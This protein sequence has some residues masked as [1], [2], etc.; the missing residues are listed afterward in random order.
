MRTRTA[1]EIAAI[2]RAD[3]VYLAAL[4]T[5]AACSRLFVRRV[6]SSWQF[7]DERTGIVELLVSELASN[8]IQASGAAEARLVG[9]PAS[10]ERKLIGIRLL[11]FQASLVIEVWD[12]SPK[13]PVLLAP[14]AALEHGRGLQLVDALSTRW[15]HYEASMGGKVVWCEI[16]R[17]DTTR[18]GASHRGLFRPSCRSASQRLPRWSSQMSSVGAGNRCA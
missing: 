5:S 6:C 2:H 8:A 1:P 13:P 7:D 10:G 15:G 9:E 17:Q 14:T 4:V 16:A 12:A 11:E 3:Q 18:T